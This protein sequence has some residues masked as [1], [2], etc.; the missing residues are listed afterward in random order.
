MDKIFR[1]VCLVV[2]LALVLSLGVAFV[3]QAMANFV[4][5]AITVDK[6]VT[7]TEIWQKGSGMAPET[8]TVTLTVTSMLPQGDVYFGV[9]DILSSYINLEDAFTITPDSIT[10]SPAGV[11]ILIWDLRPLRPGETWTVSFRISSDECG[12]GLLV[13]V[14]DWS[15]VHYEYS[16]GEG[17]G[18]VD[19]PEVTI[20]VL[21]LEVEPARLLVRN[22]LI[23]PTQAYPGDQVTISADVV[24]Q[25]GVRGSKNIELV[26]NGQA[27]QSIRVG[28][29]PGA[30]QHITFTTSKTVPGTYEVYIE[31]QA[32]AFNVLLRPHVTSDTGTAGGLSTGAIIAIVVIAV[33]FLVGMIIVFMR[34]RRPA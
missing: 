10:A 34:I 12:S 5:E 28:V 9:H 23:Q 8:A 33:I 20:D 27:E 3:P 25:G 26:I 1:P 6:Q 11:T 15:Y 18:S 19:F 22:L 32:S 17:H 29:D 2:I 14:P 30:A 4:D 31:G 16:G 24:N 21:C 13:D 7:P